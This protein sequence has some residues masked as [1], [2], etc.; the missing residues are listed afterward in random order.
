MNRR[1][2]TNGVAYNSLI[3]TFV[4]VLTTVIGIVVTKLLSVYFSLEEYLSLIHI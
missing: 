4:S 3:L 1:L 2:E